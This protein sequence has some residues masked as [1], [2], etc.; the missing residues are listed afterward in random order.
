MKAGRFTDKITV[1]YKDVTIDSFGGEVETWVDRYVGVW[2]QPKAIGS[3]AAGGGEF[4]NDDQMQ[5]TTK[6]EFVVRYLP[7]LELTDRII[8][9]GGYF[10]IYQVFPIGRRE[11]MRIRGSWSDN[12]EGD[13]FAFDTQGAQQ[14]VQGT[15]GQTLEQVVASLSANDTG[16]SLEELVTFYNDAN[17][18]GEPRIA[19]PNF[20]HRDSHRITGGQTNPYGQS[21]YYA[22]LADGDYTPGLAPDNI[23]HIAELDTTDVDLKTLVNNN[24]FGNKRRFTFDDGTEAT[25]QNSVNPEAI[26]QAAA[27]MGYTGTNTRYVIDHWT[28]LGWFLNSY[29]ATASNGGEWYDAAGFYNFFTDYEDFLDKPRTLTYGGYT[30]WRRPTVTEFTMSVGLEDSS[31]YLEAHVETADSGVG[32][33]FPGVN[34]RYK[35]TNKRVL[36][37]GPVDYSDNTPS[38][39]FIWRHPFTQAT[40]ALTSV[41]DPTTQLKFDGTNTR[42]VSF[43]CRRHYSNQ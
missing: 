29:N 2:A 17:S 10:D 36:L 20:L 28:G 22:R 42:E 9:E 3:S 43:L 15:G 24:E 40:G 11:G 34:A 14:I 23:L 21:S 37:A 35:S 31:N 16:L 4:N 26:D 25:M 18:A 12:Q 27:D 32:I 19:Y 5:G 8:W 41:F 33:Y 38:G 30:D 13:T 6:Y 39:D 7:G 1:Q